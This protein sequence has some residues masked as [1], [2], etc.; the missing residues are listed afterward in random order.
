MKQDDIKKEFINH[1]WKL[2]SHY[3]L[4]SSILIMSLYLSTTT[5]FL[6]PLE[7]DTTTT[8]FSSPEL[9]PPLIISNTNCFLTFSIP[10]SGTT[11][12]S[13]IVTSAFK[14]ISELSPTYSV[15]NE[16][17]H[18]RLTINKT[19]IFFSFHHKH[20]GKVYSGYNNQAKNMNLYDFELPI[21]L[22]SQN[23]LEKNFSLS[24]NSLSRLTAI[25]YIKRYISTD[26]IKKVER[27][28]FLG[29]K[30]FQKKHFTIF[31]DPLS[32]VVSYEKYM[33]PSLEGKKL[34]DIVKK[35]CK[36]KIIETALT[37]ELV[38][39]ILPELGYEFEL[40]Y[41]RDLRQ[42][43]YIFV[44]KFFK[45]MN[46]ELGRE[47][48]RIIDEVVKDT[49]LERMKKVQEEVVQGEVETKLGGLAKGGK[50]SRKVRNAE[51][52]GYLNELDTT[53]VE[54]CYEHMKKYL[55][56]DLLDKFEIF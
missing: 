20:H 23:L 51:I 22:I 3:F 7:S 17:R 27:M 56:K 14:H 2:N 50:N 44:K 49:S 29:N 21:N 15:V 9:P 45:S 25:E 40:L 55:Q 43:S 8:S 38:Y 31:R 19:T 52:K 26:K 28:P 24:T 37:Y 53:V 33:K 34:N 48:E 39:N 16:E 32:V 41:F 6:P 10:K 5:K 46:L 47:E 30:K 13:W 42:D 1:Q 12:L 35:Q 4:F 36:F 11:V 18:N 54:E